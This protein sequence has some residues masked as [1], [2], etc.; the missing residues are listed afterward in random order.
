MWSGFLAPIVKAGF[1]VI[2]PGD[3]AVACFQ[4]CF[5]FQC[6]P[7]SMSLLFSS[8]V[9]L[10]A[11]QMALKRLFLAALVPFAA[12]VNAALPLCYCWAI[13]CSPEV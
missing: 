13:K 8:Y 7:L 3:A 2:G 6:C 4:F 10:L 12:V 1:L 11:R 9:R 5:F